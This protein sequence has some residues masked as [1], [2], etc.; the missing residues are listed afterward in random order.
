MHNLTKFQKDPTKIS[1][2]ITVIVAG[3][4]ISFLP[5][6]LSFFIPMIVDA[7]INGPLIVCCEPA[8]DPD[9][10]AMVNENR[11]IARTI[12]HV[13]LVVFSLIYALWLFAIA[14]S[15]LYKGKTEIKVLL[16]GLTAISLVLFFA[17]IQENFP[18]D[19]EG[20][21]QLAWDMW[22]F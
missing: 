22:W 3:I 9:Y 19:D 15:P 13:C 16:V 14:K 12:I 2:T 10:V 18:V 7:L 20:W 5:I 11:L 8:G 21:W 1:K 17:L 6:M 4:A